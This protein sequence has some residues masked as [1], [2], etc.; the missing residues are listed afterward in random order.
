MVILKLFND[1]CRP[2][3]YKLM[4]F[5][6][7]L[8]LSALRSLVDRNLIQGINQRLTRDTEGSLGAVVTSE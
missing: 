4:F 2:D 3:R 1:R 6:L 8:Q 5:Y 7:F